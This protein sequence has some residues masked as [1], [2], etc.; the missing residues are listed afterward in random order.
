MVVCLTIQ[1]LSR[2]SLLKTLHR[3]STRSAANTHLPTTSLRWPHHNNCESFELLWGPCF[4]F[5]TL[6]SHRG[7]HN[8]TSMGSKKQ[9]AKQAKPGKAMMVGTGRQPINKAEFGDSPFLNVPREV[10]LNMSAAPDKL[11]NDDDRSATRSKKSYSSLASHQKNR[12]NMTRSK[13]RLMTHMANSA[14]RMP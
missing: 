3:I 14:V 7:N 5:S 12:R 10:W 6:K 9:R 8:L 1:Y 11:T 4:S 2:P 13:L